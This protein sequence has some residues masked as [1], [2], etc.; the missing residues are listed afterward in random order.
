MSNRINLKQGLRRIVLA[1]IGFC[2]ICALG[3]YFTNGCIF[4][5]YKYADNVKI[6]NPDNNKTISLEEYLENYY[7]NNTKYVS[8]WDIKCYPYKQYCIYDDWIYKKNK[9]LT[10]KIKDKDICLKITAPS[11]LQY[12]F[13]QLWDFIKIFLIASLLYGIYLILEL[14]FCWI[15]KGFKTDKD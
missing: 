8:L 1:F 5:E 9:E 12:F 7:H 13:W 15:I 2:V 6:T 10:L 14:V 11:C 3:F 4:N